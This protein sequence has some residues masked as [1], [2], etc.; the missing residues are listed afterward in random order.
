MSLL[1]CLQCMKIKLIKIGLVFIFLSKF[2]CSQNISW[3][4]SF[5]DWY[6]YMAKYH[7]YMKVNYG[8]RYEIQF[9]HLNK[10]ELIESNATIE[11]VSDT[12]VLGIWSDISIDGI[13][14]TGKLNASFVANAIFFGRA[15]VFVEITHRKNESK[16]ER[17]FNKMVMTIV[18]A[19]NYKST[20]EEFYEYYEFSFYTILRLL[21]G[22]AI[23]WRKVASILRKP[24]ALGI[25]VVCNFVFIPLVRRNFV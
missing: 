22:M 21:C 1:N 10:T 17:S 16:I 14:K 23:D 11:V 24:N 4:V 7:P 20:F 25:S 5:G 9:I 15:N 13:D 2:S 6:P 19:R 12:P 3:D 8:Q 18:R